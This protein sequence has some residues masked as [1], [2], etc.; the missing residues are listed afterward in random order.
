MV[1]IEVNGL[2]EV[3]RCRID[4]QLI[5]QND[6]ELLED[7]VRRPSTRPSPRASRC[8]PTRCAI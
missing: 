3:L 5:A 2:M 7:L 8:T 4:P 1:E 6:R